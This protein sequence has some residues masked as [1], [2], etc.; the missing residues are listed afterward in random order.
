[1]TLSFDLLF[2]GHLLNVNF[3]FYLSIFNKIYKF[4]LKGITDDDLIIA[5]TRD[6]KSSKRVDSESRLDNQFGN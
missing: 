2:Y 5:V 1:M 4:I 6:G 3:F